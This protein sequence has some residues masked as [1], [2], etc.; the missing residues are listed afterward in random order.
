MKAPLVS[1]KI[2]HLNLVYLVFRIFTLKVIIVI[3]L[4]GG[5]IGFNTGLQVYAQPEDFNT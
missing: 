5:P 4:A 1:C 2:K 3:E